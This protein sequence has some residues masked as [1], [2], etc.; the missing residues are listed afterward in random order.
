MSTLPPR[1][2]LAGGL[3]CLALLAAPAAWAQVSGFGGP[4]AVDNQLSSDR[5]QVDALFEPE[6]LDPYFAFKERLAEDTG[7]SF[8]VDY[9][10]VGRTA[11]ESLGRDTAGGGVVRLF[12]SWELAFRGTP[13]TGALVFK[14]EHR[15]GYTAVPPSAFGFETG[16]VGIIDP[17]F[18][19]QGLRL[20]NLYWRQRLFERRATVT[21]GFLDTTDYVDAF[22]L[23]SPWSHFTN[24]VFSTGSATIGLPNDATLG[25]AGA[26][27]LTDNVYAIAGLTDANA[28]PTKPFEGFDTFFNENEYFSS[29]ELGWTTGQDRL[30]F[31][32]IHA[33]LWHT[34]GSTALSVPNGW[35]VAASATWWIDDRWLPFLRGGWSQDGGTLLESS[36]GAGF[37]WQPTPGPGRDVLGF[38]LNWGR[39]SEDSFGPGLDDQYTAELF[40]RVNLGT[41]LAI[42][43]D[44]QMI[45]N[46]ALNPGTDVNTIF[47]LRARLAL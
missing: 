32:N 41:N 6:F 35:G 47:G 30:I 11:T 12:G 38:G 24:L 17:T 34:D 5:A 22:A 27:M 7:L 3:V 4:D 36:L 13:D 1:S 25:V 31:D 39:P 40:Y 26:A 15:H 42:T 14:G 16:Y 21:A 43:P 8:G 45:F 23:G 2:A 46:P 20:T 44:L 19:D 9:N 10:A 18:S 33:T 28:D 37:G 29:F